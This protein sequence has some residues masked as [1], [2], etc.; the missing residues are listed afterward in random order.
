MAV[1]IGL[2]LTSY[3]TFSIA[4]GPT[5]EEEALSRLARGRYPLLIT[6]DGKNLLFVDSKNR[7]H[8]MS[9]DDQKSELI[10]AL[11][12]P[13]SGMAASASGN[14]VVFHSNDFPCIGIVTFTKELNS[15]K[16]LVDSGRTQWISL[17]AKNAYKASSTCKKREDFR[18]DEDTFINSNSVALSENGNLLAFAGTSIQIINLQDNRRVIEI[19]TGETTVLKL[20]FIEGDAKLFVVQAQLGERWESASE[21]SDMQF[22]IWDLKKKELLNLH[23]TDTSGTLLPY[24]LLWDF[25]EKTGALWAINTSGSYWD[26]KTKKNRAI[27]PYLT[28]LNDCK[29]AI[30]RSVT[31]STERDD[32]SWL[33]FTADPL[34]RWI[35][36]VLPTYNSKTKMTGSILSIRDSRN[37]KTLSQWKV[38]EELRSITSTQD[39]TTIF[40]ITGGRTKNENGQATDSASSFVEGGKLRKFEFSAKLKSLVT[41]TTSKNIVPSETA[42]LIEDETIGARDIQI[43]KSKITPLWTTKIAYGENNWYLDRD[44][45]LW[46]DK[47]TIVEQRD[48]ENGKLITAIPTPRNDTVQSI[49]VFNRHQFVSWQGDSVSIRP[50]RPALSNSDRKILVRRPGWE[51]KSVIALG[52]NYGVR[53]IN[54]KSKGDEEYPEGSALAIVYNKD[55]VEISVT[56]GRALKGQTFFEIEDGEG[57]EDVFQNYIPDMNENNA[58]I[59]ERSFAGSIRAKKWIENKEK[60]TMNNSGTETLFWHGL[61]LEKL[62]EKNREEVRLSRIEDQIIPLKEA[63][64]ARIGTDGIAIFDAEKRKQVAFI[65]IKDIHRV[66]LDIKTQVL[67]IEVVRSDNN[68]DEKNLRLFRIR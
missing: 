52:D 48:L 5:N 7:L 47:H 4:S 36:Y 54:N 37:G 9:V 58:Y 18:Y 59:W 25:S 31:L 21:K 43:S 38:D 19:P 20:R 3:A 33:E 64:G 63:F 57:S 16:S 67:V 42:C 29:S 2:V 14:K 41:E 26:D 13:I 53:W 66:D 51:A 24:D 10:V 65:S 62:N 55:G 46:L 68:N 11:P 56:K 17:S 15:G 61:R 39:G 50:F 12:G 45:S 23:R 22:G 60:F 32:D 6:N 49:P 1:F 30:Q 34:G 28:N 40:A 27:Q 35:A 44:G 8:R